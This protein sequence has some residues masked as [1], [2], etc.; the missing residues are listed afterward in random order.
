[1]NR[2]KRTI[3]LIHSSTVPSI[4]IKYGNRIAYLSQIM[5]EIG[6]RL[7][8]AADADCGRIDQLKS[9]FLVVSQ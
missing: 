5:S 4:K 3:V 6:V 9:L 2:V 7:F 1:M 8:A